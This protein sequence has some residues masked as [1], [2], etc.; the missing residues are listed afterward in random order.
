MR[1]SASPAVLGSPA[2]NSAGRATRSC[3]TRATGSRRFDRPARPPLSRS[4]SRPY[5]PP[6]ARDRAPQASARSRD[7]GAARQARRPCRR[8]RP[9]RPRRRERCVRR[10]ARPHGRRSG[11]RRRPRSIRVPPTRTGGRRH[12]RSVSSTVCAGGSAVWSGIDP[13][14][15]RR[16]A[17]LE[18]ERVQPGTEWLV[19]RERPAAD[20]AH[21]VVDGEPDGAARGRRPA[22]GRRPPPPLR[23]G[24]ARRPRDRRARARGRTTSDGSAP[25][26]A[27]CGRR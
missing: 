8:C 1:A 19:G 15:V 14:P 13:H 23:R 24:R 7:H 6:R 2:A 21:A 27:P 11:G 3:P 5:S 16:P 26:R 10:R 18:A 22:P 12:I 25:G 9:G 4:A 17:V 20:L